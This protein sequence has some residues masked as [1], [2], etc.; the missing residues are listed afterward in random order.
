MVNFIIIA[1]V[2][3]IVAGIGFYLYRAKKRG[4]HC[5]GCPYG[6]QCSKNCQGSCDQG[7]ND[8]DNKK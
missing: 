2:V 5:I 8:N 7:C 4:D 6:K 3:L 1:I